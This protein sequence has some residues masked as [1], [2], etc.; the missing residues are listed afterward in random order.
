MY[1]RNKMKKLNVHLSESHSYLLNIDHLVYHYFDHSI[2]FMLNLL[3][4]CSDLFGTVLFRK[5]VCINNIP[6]SNISIGN[7][8]YIKF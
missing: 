5:H 4:F 7:E 6:T 2:L 8:I 1:I 3:I